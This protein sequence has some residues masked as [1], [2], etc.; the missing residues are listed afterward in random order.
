MGV[1]AY[2][3][4]GTPPSQSS[5]VKGEEEGM[6]SRFCGSKSYAVGGISP[7]SQSSPVKGEEGDW[8]PAYAG[9]TEVW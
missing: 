5:P 3:R 1:L 9:M 4:V 7:P 6:G 8:I 2:F